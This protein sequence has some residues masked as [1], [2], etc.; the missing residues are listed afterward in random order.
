MNDDDS[1]NKLSLN[2]SKRFFTLKAQVADQS[3]LAD[4]AHAINNLATAQ[5]EKDNPSLVDVKER[6]GFSRVVE[7]EGD[8]H[9]RCDPGDDV[10]VVG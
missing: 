1:G 2:Y 8:I 5:G 3:G 7:E 9:C 6:G 4:A 10:G